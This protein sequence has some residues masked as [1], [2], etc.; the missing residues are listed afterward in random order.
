MLDDSQLPLTDDGVWCQILR[1]PRPSARPAPALFLDRDGV[2]IEEGHFVHDPAQVRL[3]P[4][5]AETIRAAN[6]RGHGVVIVTNQSGIGRGYFGWPEFA[7][8]QTRV[9]ED[10]AGRGAYIDAVLACPFHEGGCA[11]YDI[12][13]HPYRKPNPGMLRLAAERL[14][15]DLAGSWIV[16][17]HATDIGAGRAAGLAGAVH[18]ATGHG[19]EPDQ[20]P[21]ALAYATEDFRVLVAASLAEAAPLIPFLNS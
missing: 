7:A 13:N 19:S 3:L 6:T 16:G 15:I 8:T 4:G 2:V 9:I 5:S 12:A 18:V 14:R 17:D 10:L 1:R 21:R 11:P 20:R